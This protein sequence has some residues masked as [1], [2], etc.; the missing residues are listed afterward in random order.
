MLL[1]LS[2]SVFSKLFPYL[3][4]MFPTPKNTAF[5]TYTFERLA[6]LKIYDFA[7]YP[8]GSSMVSFSNT[9]FHY[10][11]G[12]NTQEK[13]DEIYGEGNSY[14]AEYWQYDARL[15]RRWNNDPRPN[16]S[17]SLYACFGNNPIWFTDVNGDTTWVFDEKGN[18]LDVINDDLPNQTHFIKAAN[19]S[20]GYYGIMYDNLEEK[21]DGSFAIKNPNKFANEIRKNSTAFYTK[22]TEEVMKKAYVNSAPD[23]EF[24]FGLAFKQGSKELEFLLCKSCNAVYDESSSTYL[25]YGLDDIESEYPDRKFFTTGHSHPKN[26]GIHTA[27]PTHSNNPKNQSDYHPILNNTGHPAIVLSAR[28]ISIY[29]TNYLRNGNWVYQKFD[30]FTLIPWD[31]KFK[32]PNHIATNW[33]SYYSRYISEQSN[34]RR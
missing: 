26:G 22:K 28:G 33:D 23:K 13:D 17:I 21:K 19:G 10:S 11:F 16:P 14:S 30:T 4:F 8:F 9:E 20:K 34:K 2:K 29:P 1:I 7:T 24:G 12:M 3:R 18:S 32:I 27:R 15:G 5:T 25:L 31:V 6:K